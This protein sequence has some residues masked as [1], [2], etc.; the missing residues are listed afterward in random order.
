[1]TP[2][3]FRAPGQPLPAKPPKFPHKWPPNAPPNRKCPNRKPRG[4]RSGPP[5]ALPE[6]HPV[7]TQGHWRQG[8]LMA[9]RGRDVDSPPEISPPF[10]AENV[11][12][13][14]AWA[15]RKGRAPTLDAC[16]ETAGFLSGLHRKAQWRSDPTAHASL[17]AAARWHDETFVGY[18]AMREALAQLEVADRQLERSL[19][20]LFADL[21]DSFHQDVRSAAYQM[22]RN[23]RAAAQAM[24][25]L[26]ES[27]PPPAQSP[28][29]A[30]HE[31]AA[32]LLLIFRT[33]MRSVEPDK[34][35]PL[36]DDAPATRFI[37]HALYL[38]NGTTVTPSAIVK[39]LARLSAEP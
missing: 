15:L 22:Q 23:L 13:L 32:V 2:L 31:D 18:G 27:P 37:K 6:P 25:E 11:Q 26:V 4:K 1:M 28:R 35:F 9:K 29:V 39:A 24:A 38:T 12:A 16:A 8:G 36:W 19:S 3:A 7:S 21:P 34:K 20:K 30:W 10:T 33:A 14:F 17:A 5:A